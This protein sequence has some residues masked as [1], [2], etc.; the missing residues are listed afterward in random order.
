MCFLKR[1]YVRRFANDVNRRMKRRLYRS[2]LAASEVQL[3]GEGAG[4]RG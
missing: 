1:L 3:A 2:L 4:N